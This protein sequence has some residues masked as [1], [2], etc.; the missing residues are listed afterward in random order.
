MVCQSA[1]MPEMNDLLKYKGKIIGGLIGLL[2]RRPLFIVLGIVIGHLYD[3]GM[4]SGAKKTSASSGNGESDPYAVLGVS[5]QAT[6]DE[7]EQAYRRRMSEYHP[8]KVASAA[9]E[10]KALAE[11]R[12]SEINAAYEQIQKRRKNA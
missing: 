2:L 6:Q 12:A 3:T 10:L 4:F 9:P 1:R 8:D 11:R 5:G 7:I